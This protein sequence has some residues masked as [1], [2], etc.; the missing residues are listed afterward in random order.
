MAGVDVLRVTVVRGGRRVDVAVAA[1]V[2]VVE[3]LPDLARTLRGEEGCTLATVLGHPLDP[4]VGLGAQQVVD[5]QVLTLLST[6]E[7]PG[8]RHDDVADAVRSAG[9]ELFP[10]WRGRHTRTAAVGVAVLAALVAGVVAPR[11]PGPVATVVSAVFAAA[12]T[13]A[14]VVALR[15]GHTGVAAWVGGAVGGWHVALVGAGVSPG[16]RAHPWWSL[17][18][19]TEPTVAGV[20][21]LLVLW[22]L[23]LLAAAAGHRE[24]C[25]VPL[26]TGAVAVLAGTGATVFG[27]TP[28]DVLWPL[29]TVA[30]VLHRLLPAVVV[31]ALLV[32][33]RP[34]P[35][36]PVALRTDL[37]VVDRLLVSSAVVVVLTCVAVVPHAVVHAGWGVAWTVAVAFTFGFRARHETLRDHVVVALGGAAAT[38]AVAAGAVASGGHVPWVL[39][40]CVVV[41]AVAA[42]HLVPSEMRPGGSRWG[43]V[44]DQVERCAVGAL[45]PV[46]LVACGL[47]GSPV[48]WWG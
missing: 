33:D 40:A 5:G 15:R 41:A 19:G 34:G 45:A 27:V 43:W 10:R 16:M 6:D 30:L 37:G 24:W 23:V 17:Q 21:T 48:G 39:L 46:W 26:A 13:T 4:S 3:L 29:A 31:D 2:P 38:G 35:A 18:E 12:A 11:D 8:G 47:V 25:V 44:G 28:G 7:V 36:E 42:V 14:L 1:G 9:A 20:G 22:G 32:T